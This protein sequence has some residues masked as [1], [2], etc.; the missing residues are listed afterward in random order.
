MAQS[1]RRSLSP[2]AAIRHVRT[3]DNHLPAAVTDEQII[4]RLIA[5]R[6]D[7]RFVG[8][9]IEL[10]ETFGEDQESIAV[11]LGVVVA[12]VERVVPRPVTQQRARLAEIIKALA[13]ASGT[14]N[15]VRNVDANRR[16]RP[17][18]PSR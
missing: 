8:K 7:P 13:K 17:V 11:Q 1:D 2:F 14:Q 12:A 6:V 4:Q 15:H 5:D 16:Y 9:R 3:L 18:P 10:L